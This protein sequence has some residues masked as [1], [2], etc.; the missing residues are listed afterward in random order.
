MSEAVRKL[1]EAARNMERRL[2][3]NEYL[4]TRSILRNAIKAVESELSQSHTDNTASERM[5]SEQA[6]ETV[7]FR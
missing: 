5:V 7:G 4:I 2:P 6:E 1:V 3:P